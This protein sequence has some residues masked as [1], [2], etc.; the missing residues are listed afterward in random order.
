MLRRALAGILVS[1]ATSSLAFAD[2]VTIGS[3]RIDFDDA[4]HRPKTP[5]E[6]EFVTNFLA[7]ART[8]DLTAMRALVHSASLACTRDGAPS[9]FLDTTLSRPFRQAIPDD[10]RV[11]FAPIPDPE[12]HV[13]KSELMTLPLPPTM[14]FAVDYN[15]LERDSA[16]VVRR[17]IG[18][19]IVRM[20][21]PE[22]EALKLVE[23]CLTPAG[24]TKFRASNPEQPR[25][26]Q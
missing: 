17:N 6:K 9:R 4:A 3:I 24:E 19:T 14:I 18:M 21:A 7:A 2:A 12:Q 22:N 26:D 10:A 11:G 15:W 5:A 13:P 8:K 25:K 16:G 23:Y 20:L 1:I